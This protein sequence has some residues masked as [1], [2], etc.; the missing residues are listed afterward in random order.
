MY[1]IMCIMHVTIMPIPLDLNWNISET[2]MEEEEQ[3]LLSAIQLYTTHF[4]RAVA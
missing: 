2:G 3:P 1:I 4:P